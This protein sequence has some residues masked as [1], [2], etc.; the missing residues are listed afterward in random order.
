MYK[1]WVLTS[2]EV[3]AVTFKATHT[4]DRQDFALLWQV[5]LVRGG[6]VYR[7][8]MFKVECV[9]DGIGIGSVVI[10]PSRKDP[11]AFA[12]ETGWCEIEGR[13]WQALAARVREW[14]VNQPEYARQVEWTSKLI[15]WERSMDINVEV[16]A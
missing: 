14:F 1:Q 8:D 12:V 2:E 16:I 4:D 3:A 9:C 13:Q 7:R 11:T 6:A 10:E 5:Y 15:T